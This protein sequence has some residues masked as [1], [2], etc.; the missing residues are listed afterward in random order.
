MRHERTDIERVT[1]NAVLLTLWAMAQEQN[2]EHAVGDRLKA[3][4][5]AFL[6]TYELFWDNVKALNLA[7]YRHTWG[8]MSNQVYTAWDE[9]QAAG[10][11]REQEEI[12]ITETGQRLANEFASE[13]LSLPV[14][15]PI[16]G[17]LQSVTREYGPL[18][19]PE[20]LRRVYAMHCYT[21]HDIARQELVKTMPIG[22]DI[23][24]LLSE[25][26]ADV[27]LTV[28]PGWEMTLELALHSE[29]L[30]NLRRGIEDTHSGRLHGWEAL[31]TDV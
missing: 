28:P 25:D 16:L 11:L 18:P 31:G 15:Q 19:R 12:T 22:R 9:L 29:A 23:T 4:K 13:V 10:L 21:L 1:D 14:N 30:R 20:V 26:E 8:P 27:I 17:S 2:P 3:M 24:G 6:T 5:L 7:F